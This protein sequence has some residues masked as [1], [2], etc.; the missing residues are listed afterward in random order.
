MEEGDDPNFISDTNNLITI[1]QKGPLL[2]D[3]RDSDMAR[4]PGVSKVA[5][6]GRWSEAAEPV[7]SVGSSLTV[8]QCHGELY[9]WE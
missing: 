7:N 2:R 4:A 5:T 6:T 3:I 9:S 1:K 8:L